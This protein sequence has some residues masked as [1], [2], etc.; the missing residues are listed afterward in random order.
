MSISSALSNALSGL[1]ANARRAEIG[2]ANIANAQT[3]GYGRRIVETASASIGGASAGVA[4]VG[5]TRSINTVILGDRRASDGALAGARQQAQVLRTIEQSIGSVDDPSSLSARLVDLELALEAAAADPASDNRLRTGVRALKDL[6]LAVGQTARTIQT[7]RARADAD[8]AAS[9]ATL[10]A[11]LAQVEALNSDIGKA[12]ATGRDPS[13]LMDQRQVSIDRISALVPVREVAQSNGKVALWTVGG[14]QLLDGAAPR[15][16]FSPR[17]VITADMTLASG[18]LSGLSLSGT[19]MTQAVGRLTGGALEAQFILRD[20]TLVA[21]QAAVDAIALDLVGRFSDPA[22]DP[23]L[24]PGA[25]GLLTDGGGAF[26]V[27]NEIGLAQRLS[28]HL[29][30]DPAGANEIHRLRDGLAATAHGEV[31]NPAQLHRYLDVLSEQRA[32]GGGEALSA[33]DRIARTSERLS[34]DRLVAEQ[35]VAFA[36]ARRDSLHAAEL[37]GG[38][39]TDAELQRLLV[40]EQAYAANARVMQTIDQMM[41]RLMEI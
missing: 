26:I 5:I 30:L 31:G 15:I 32:F 19:P 9:V 40:V 34:T 3:D 24:T 16:D 27:G 35:E 18:A 17:S 11:S 29:S 21:Q 41:S 7:Q 14:A 13:A 2:A 39:D 8:I 22:V 36:T 12:V 38:V 37:E 25:A 10:N 4:V 20:E 6:A 23:T 28:I 1:T 33:F